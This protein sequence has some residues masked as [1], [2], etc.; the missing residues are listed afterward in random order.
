MEIEYLENKI[1]EFIGL[2]EK[3]E[4][5]KVNYFNEVEVLIKKIKLILDIP[6]YKSEELDE[7]NIPKVKP[8]NR[9]PLTK[10]D[11]EMAEILIEKS[12]L[13]RRFIRDY[14]RI[15]TSI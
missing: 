3:I 10:E 1:L 4:S 2:L 9:P 5:I 7:G 12:E 6:I 14:E 8:E 15:D 13:M 11:V